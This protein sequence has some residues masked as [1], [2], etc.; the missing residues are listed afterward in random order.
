M[1]SS[2]RKIFFSI[3]F[4]L[5]GFSI[6]IECIT[7]KNE[8]NFVIPRVRGVDRN[9]FSSSSNIKNTDLLVT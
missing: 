8:M 4:L 2:S 1:E 7:I 5:I 9:L 3:V 6:I